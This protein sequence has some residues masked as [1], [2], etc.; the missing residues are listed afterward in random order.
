MND[1]PSTTDISLLEAFFAASDAVVADA[2]LAE[3]IAGRVEPLVKTLIRGKLHVSLQPDD[4]RQVNQDAFDL[5]SDI[6]TLI[7]AKLKAPRTGNGAGRIENLEA[8]IR[9]VAAN[10]TN[11]YLRSKYPNR[12]RLKN[13]LRYLLTH[14]RRYSLWEMDGGVWVCGLSEWNGNTSVERAADELG[15]AL[16]QRGIVADSIELIEL[17]GL[18]LGSVTAPLRF[19]ELVSVIYELRRISEPTEV[20]ASET[21]GERTLEYEN[22]LLDRLEKADQ[23]KT[24]WIEIGKLPLRH[25]A[26]LLLNLKNSHGDGLITLLPLTRTATIR[27]IAEMLEFPVVDFAAIWNELPWDDHAIAAHL[28]LTRQQVINLRQSARAAL[29]RRLVSF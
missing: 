15:S 27:Q 17:V 23:L 5:V 14:D 11:H 3:L 7:V 12:L 22:D 1:R 16:E 4:E 28:G 20:L 10:A 18:V 13:Q 24:L 8:Y 9:A 2:V 29:K 6:K 25:R 21:E 19:A 26:S